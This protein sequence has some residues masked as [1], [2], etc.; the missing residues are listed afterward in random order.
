MIT[1]SK[2]GISKPK[3][4]SATKYPLPD[5]VDIISTT[6][7][8]ASKHAHWRSAMQDEFNA[9]QSTGTWSLVPFTSQQNIV[10]CKWVFRVKKHPNGIIDR[11][12]ARLVA[13]GFHQQAGLDYRETFNPIAKP[14]TIRILLSLAVQ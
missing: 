6:Y 14:V 3:A 11:Y 10:R 7:L 9:L 8:Q 2:A 1:R 12:K 4:Y 13:K 5:T